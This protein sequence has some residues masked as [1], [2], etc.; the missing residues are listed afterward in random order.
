MKKHRIER[1]QERL[2]R[3]HQ[4]PSDFEDQI[5]YIFENHRNA[6]FSLPKKSIDGKKL[7]P[8]KGR[9]HG[10][11]YFITFVKT[12]DLRLA[13]TIHPK[14]KPIIEST[15]ANMEKLILDQPEKFT[16]EGKTEHVVAPQ[17]K[18]VLNDNNQSNKINEDV[19]LVESPMDGIDIIKD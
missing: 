13:D 17:K 6:D 3:A 8:P 15:G 19:L 2:A 1:M 7:I 4:R 5:T 10:D 11:E 12:G 18:V 14:P 16:H 9:F